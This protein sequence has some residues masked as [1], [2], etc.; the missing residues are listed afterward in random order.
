MVFQ[1]VTN[2]G[3]K[4]DAGQETKRVQSLNVYKVRLADYAGRCYAMLKQMMMDSHN[5]VVCKDED[6]TVCMLMQA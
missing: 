4:E 1:N 5:R 2:G 6:E 3:M